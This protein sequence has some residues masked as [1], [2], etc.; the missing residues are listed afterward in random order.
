MGG[1]SSITTSGEVL[2]HLHFWGGGP[3]PSLL[4]WGGSLPSPLPR[5]PLPSL[6]PGGPLPSLLPGWSSSITTSKGV[7]CDQSHN[8]LDVTCLFSKHQLM[9]LACYSCLYTAAAPVHHGKVTWDPLKRIGQ[10][11]IYV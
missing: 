5:G 7:P 6:L 3:L 9:G 2:F 4:L 10:T 1:S 11:D 8:G